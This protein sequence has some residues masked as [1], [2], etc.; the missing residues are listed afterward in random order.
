[1]AELDAWGSRG[2]PSLSDLEGGALPY[3]QAVVKE[4]LRLY[5]PGSTAVREA[6]Q[7]WSLGGLSVP[8]LTAVQVGGSHSPPIACC[9]RARGC[10]TCLPV[11]LW[12]QACLSGGAAHVAQVS[13]YA[14][15]RNPR[16]WRDPAAFRP[17]RFM[18]GTPDAAE[19][20]GLGVWGQS[21]LADRPLT[22]LFSACAVGGAGM[23]AFPPTPLLRPLRRS[24]TTRTSR[25]ATAAASALATGAL[26]RLLGL[27]GVAVEQ[28]PPCV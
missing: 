12:P 19:V 7:G 23:P 5:P 1:M 17:D 26:C 4:A 14:M 24:T 2:P 27:M 21:H 15:Q 20:A 11:R 9:C 13:I 18:P 6:P 8:A 10:S 22:N 3:A 25:S 28:L 16:H